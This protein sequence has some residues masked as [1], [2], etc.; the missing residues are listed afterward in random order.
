MKVVLKVVLKVEAMG[1]QRMPVI[2]MTKHALPRYGYCASSAVFCI[3]NYGASSAAFCMSINDY[4]A[5]SA[6]F[7]IDNYCASSAVFCM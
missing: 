1:G 4:C 5:S 7:C 2:M 3:D 6:V